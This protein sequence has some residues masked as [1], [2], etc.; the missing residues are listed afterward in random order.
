MVIVRKRGRAIK[1]QRIGWKVMEKL[2]GWSCSENS[3]SQ[4]VISFKPSLKGLL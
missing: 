2:G 4:K 3:I 1:K